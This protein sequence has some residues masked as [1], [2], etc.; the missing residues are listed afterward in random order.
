MLNSAGL[1]LT[2]IGAIGFF[3]WETLRQLVQ[4]GLTFRAL[5]EQMYL[6]G[7]RSMATTMVSG[8]FVGAIMAIQINL[9][10]KDFGAQ[11]FLGGLSTSTTIRN[12]GPVLIGFILSGKVGAFTSAEL[13]TMRV[14]DQLDAIRCLGMDP[15]RYVI[16]PRMVAV[17][18][19]SFFLLIV[20]L[21]VSVGGGMMLASAQ[22]GVNAQSFVANIP[23]VVGWWSV[24]MGVFKSFVFGTLIAVLCCYYG[25]HARGGAEGV[26]RAVKKSAVI[27]LICIIIADFTISSLSSLLYEMLGVDLL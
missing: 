2:E 22:L 27:T 9:Q 10:L 5:I 3:L 1:F 20:G 16:L 21:M 23:R 13:G 7:V 25:Y 14:T 26:G 17:I 24:G 4:G 15:I 19:S 11:S 6:A 18:L 12:V 8:V